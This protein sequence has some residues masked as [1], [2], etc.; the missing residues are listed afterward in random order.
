[1]RRGLPLA[2]TPAAPVMIHIGPS[3]T[4]IAH[5]PV[6]HCSVP[7]PCQMAR[8]AC[9]ERPRSCRPTPGIKRRTRTIRPWNPPV[10]GLRTVQILLIMSLSVP[11]ATLR[12]PTS[13]VQRSLR[14]VKKINWGV[15][16]LGQ[17]KHG[18]LSRDGSDHFREPY[19]TAATGNSNFLLS[20]MDCHEAHGSENIM[21]LRT[22]IN[23]EDQEGTVTSTDALS[24]NC[25]RCHQDDL[26]AAAGTGQADR[27][28]FVHHGA[29]DAPYAQGTCDDLPWCW[30]WEGALSPAAIVM[31]MAWTIAG[32]ASMLPVDGLSD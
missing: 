29:A 1:M 11:P 30:R 14:D 10:S 31:A 13:R 27:W 9:G 5:S 25:K 2:A 4:G 19:A 28:E 18:E 21:L 20:C 17:D 6:F 26:A 15:I 3:A 7:S 8:V 32:S 23:G 12:M 22:R 16:G 24:Y